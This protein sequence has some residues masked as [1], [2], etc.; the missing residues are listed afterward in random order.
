MQLAEDITL[1]G[2]LI[3]DIDRTGSGVAILNGTLLHEQSPLIEEATIEATFN[4][5][6]ETLTGTGLIGGVEATLLYESLANDTS[7]L[8]IKSQNAGRTLIGLDVLD[9]IRGG[10][11]ILKNVYQKKEFDNFK[12]E[13]KVTDFSVIEAPKSVRALSVLSVTGLYSLIEG[14]GTKFDVGIANIETAGNRRILKNVQASGEAIKFE[15]AGE[16]DRET[17]ELQ[18]RGILAPLSLL[19]DIIGVIPLVSNI[20]TGKDKT[21][22]LAT[23][24][25]MSGK[26]SNPVTTINP[27]SVLAPG[28]LRD[29]LSPDW[30]TRESGIRIDTQ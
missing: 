9:T 18:V 14:D 27:A 16:Y 7:Y 10:E 24:F 2:R 21:G 5:Q 15:L 13:I 26:L 20:V 30:L 23:Q 3:G 4:E 25:E 1:Q 22:F 12:T 28:V 8:L 19:S 17:D 29:I 11:L 6:T